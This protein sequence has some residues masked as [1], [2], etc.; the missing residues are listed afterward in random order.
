[1]FNIVHCAIFFLYPCLYTRLTWQQI[2]RGRHNLYGL[3]NP[4]LCGRNMCELSECYSSSF[5]QNRLFENGP[6]KPRTR[7][8]F[9]S[10]NV[11][12]VL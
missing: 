3:D 4:P 2:K 9:S 6:R 12:T 1:M 8:V 5:S 11:T 7:S 10:S